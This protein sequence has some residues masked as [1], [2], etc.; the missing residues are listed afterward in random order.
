MQ[1]RRFRH[2][3]LL[4]NGWEWHG[5]LPNNEGDEKQNRRAIPDL[6]SFCFGSANFPLSLSHRLFVW[7]GGWAAF[8]SWVVTDSEDRLHGQLSDSRYTRGKEA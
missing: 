3:S 5:F 4:F 8:V 1:R 6:Q 7:A 2:F